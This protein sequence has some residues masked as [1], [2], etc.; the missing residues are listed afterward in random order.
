MSLPALDLAVRYPPRGPQAAYASPQLHVVATATPPTPTEAK[1]VQDDCSAYNEDVQWSRFQKWLDDV[2]LAPEQWL[3]KLEAV[4]SSPPLLLWL[5]PLD[6]GGSLDLAGPPMFAERQRLIAQGEATSSEASQKVDRTARY[7]QIRDA[8]AARGLVG[9]AFLLAGIAYA[10]TGLAHCWSE[11]TWACKGPESE[12]CNGP[13]IAG[14]GDGPCSIEQGGL[15]MFQFD[16]GTYAATLKKYGQDVLTIAGNVS[17]AIDYVLTMVKVSSYISDVSTEDEAL[18]WLNNFD[19]DDA[20]MRDAWVKTVTQYYNGC[21]PSYGCWNQRYGLY[22]GALQHVLDD[23]DMAFWQQ[24]SSDGVSGGS[25]G[26]GLVRG[27]AVVSMTAGVLLLGYGGALWW[28]QKQAR[29]AG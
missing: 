9:K 21:K 28:R 14:S 3:E 29:L 15:G 18:A 25:S 5:R 2:S 20:S 17:H 22:N 6:E 1:A 19:V 10:E 13:V 23:T 4:P 7:A 24:Q 26:S 8:A 11:A 16:N 27:L 12:D